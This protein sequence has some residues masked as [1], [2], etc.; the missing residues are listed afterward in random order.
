MR[1]RLAILVAV[2]SAIALT[3][4]MVGIAS[5]NNG[6]H[7]GYAPNSAGWNTTDGCAGCH[8]AHTGAT[9]TLL[10]M[11]SITALCQ[12]CHSGGTGATTD[13]WDGVVRGTNNPL[14]GGG[15]MTA[16]NVA[17]GS[18]T[19][20]AVTSRHNVDGL[21]AVTG[22][23]GTLVAGTGSGMAYGGGDPS[24]TS[25]GVQGQLECTSCHNPHGSQ[26]YRILNG[27]VN[28][29]GVPQSWTTGETAT[30]QL[31]NVGAIPTEITPG[32]HNY[33]AGHD[34]AYDRGI[35]DFCATCHTNYVRG[36]TSSG[37]TGGQ[38][39]NVNGN[40]L[41]TVWRHAVSMKAAWNYSTNSWDTS[42]ANYAGLHTNS[43][44]LYGT[45]KPGANDLRRVAA[46]GN[47]TSGATNNDGTGLT[48]LTC[49]D[50]HGTSAVASGNA[51]TEA[52]TQD[53]ALLYLDNRGVCQ[54]CHQKG[55]GK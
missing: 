51:V 13:V 37:P 55:T 46:D 31:S 40:G 29:A 26:N 7:G 18:S 27:L 20:V 38:Q 11:P 9:D 33:S 28:Y 19:Q 23:S 14:N 5:A 4:A 25:V 16:E 47:I 48:C 12:S 34:V 53:S 2:A 52:K 24:T 10:T 8:R 42:V 21:S 44:N 49:H 1:R 54:Q 50:A 39:Y 3:F 22:S 32:S 30:W 45:Y 41:T 6:P 35:S 43:G 36:F 17:S 15:F